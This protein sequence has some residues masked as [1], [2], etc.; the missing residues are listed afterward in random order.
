MSFVRSVARKI[1]A[2]LPE[3]ET[4]KTFPDFRIGLLTSHSIDFKILCGVGHEPKTIAATKEPRE[5]RFCG[6]SQT[7]LYNCRRPHSSL[8]GSTPDQAYFTS[9]PLR[10]AA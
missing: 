1:A 3:F 2:N 8:D 9:L 6:R 7:S 10:T 4:I 5:E